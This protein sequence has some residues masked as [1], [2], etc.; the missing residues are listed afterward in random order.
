V[1]VINGHADL[2]DLLLDKGADPNAEGG[3]IELTVQGVHARAQKLD[4]KR[5][6]LREQLK[7][8]SSEGGGRVNIF[9]RPLQAAVHVANWHI[10]DQFIVVRMDRLRIIK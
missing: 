5:P 10:C 8:V 2:V 3:S 7:S 6:S 9:G 4:L 1:A